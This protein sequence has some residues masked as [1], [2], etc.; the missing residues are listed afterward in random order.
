[1]PAVVV[2]GTQWGDEGKGKVTDFFARE[3]DVVC[4]F[5]GGNNAGHTIV[6]NG[7]KF[8]FHLIPSGVL[9]NKELVIANGVV[10]DP[11]VLKREVETFTERFSR[12]NLWI[13]DR[14]NIITPYHRLLDGAEE[15]L[16]GSASVGTT[17]RGIGPAYSDK[18]AR[19]GIRMGDLLDP[20]A[21]K[22]KV[23]MVVEIKNRLLAAYGLGEK[24]DAEAL[25]RDL[26]GF[27]EFFAPMI[28]DTSALLNEA[29]DSG[30]RVLFEGAQGTMLDVDWGTYPYTTSSNTIAGG[31]CTGAGVG[32]TRINRVVGVAKAYT[33]RV[34]AGPL[35]TAIDG[36]LEEKIQKKGGEFGT[37]TGRRR[38]C[39]WLDL[40]VL[41]HAVRLSGI[42]SLALTKIDVL[43]GLGDIK[44]AV[45]YE[46]DGEETDFFPGSISRV[47]RAKPV[48]ETLRGWPDMRPEEWRSL[49]KGG[50][51]DLPGEVREYVSFIEKNTGAKVEMVSFGPDREDTLDLR[52]EDWWDVNR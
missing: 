51:E 42:T 35:P 14:A 31:A 20:E 26:L 9:W 12:P 37:T 52:G 49:A 16:R 30:K 10:V 15:R 21:L 25:Y 1:M 39:G 6:V 48:Y 33:T 45:R 23:D 4:R 38:R 32:P 2:V 18:I 29:L 47:E 40:V 24:I 36:D 17:K 44:V 11:Y 3:A 43:G 13:S 22:Q 5:Q 27:G 46:I 28:R 7:E 34:G 8:A 50:Y 41:K 19:H